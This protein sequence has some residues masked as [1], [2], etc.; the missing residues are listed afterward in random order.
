MFI[1]FVITL[2]KVNKKNKAWAIPVK[3]LRFKPYHIQLQRYTLSN[4]AR[5]KG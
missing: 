1:L 4:I 2:E 5:E 3:H